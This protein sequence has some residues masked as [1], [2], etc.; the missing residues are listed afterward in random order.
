MNIPTLNLIQEFITLKEEQD[1]LAQIK[2]FERKRTKDRNSIQ[3]FG[4]KLPYASNMV[5]ESI[6]EYL[7]SIC[8]KLFELNLVSKKPDSVTIN[9]Y[10]VGQGIDYHIDSNSSGE[11]ITILSLLSP[12]VMNFKKSQENF[13]IELPART[14]IQMSD[15]LRYKW[16]HAIK[17]VEDTRYSIV[18]RY[19]TN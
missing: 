9:E 6:P 15:E 2:K 18:F 7:N 11:K 4:S 17:P 12:A 5:S 1:I 16:Q 8:E 3:R 14:L 10:L 13:D 19:G